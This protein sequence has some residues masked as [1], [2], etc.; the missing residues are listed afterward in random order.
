MTCDLVPLRSVTDIAMIQVSTEFEIL[1]KIK[2]KINIIN[3]EGTRPRRLYADGRV[4]T[5]KGTVALLIPILVTLGTKNYGIPTTG[6]PNLRHFE[7]LTA[8][9]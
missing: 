4:V 1:N 8:C 5:V 7:R 2:Y 6:Y 9:I 3:A